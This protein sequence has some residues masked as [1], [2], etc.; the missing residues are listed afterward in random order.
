[1]NVRKEPQKYNTMT[2]GERIRV[3]V[4]LN[5]NKEDLSG[6]AGPEIVNAVNNAGLNLPF[7]VKYRHIAPI[8]EEVGVVV[9]SG[10]GA[11]MSAQLQLTRAL[12]TIARL[13]AQVDDLTTRTEKLTFTLSAVRAV[14]VEDGVCSEEQLEVYIQNAIMRHRVVSEL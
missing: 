9:G 12:D 1:M 4:W 7:L 6:K 5:A 2:T 10:E 11:R 13:E 8:M 14:L 3:G